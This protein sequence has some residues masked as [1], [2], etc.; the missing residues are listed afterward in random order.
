L[1]QTNAGTNYFFI[2]ET[3]FM[4]GSAFLGEFPTKLLKTTISFVMSVRLHFHVEQLCFHFVFSNMEV[5][6]IRNCKNWRF[7]KRGTTLAHPAAVNESKVQVFKRAH[8][9]I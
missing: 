3:L 8:N 2:L 5:A 7:N 1:I 6:K 9:A 4:S